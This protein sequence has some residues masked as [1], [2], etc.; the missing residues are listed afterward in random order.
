MKTMRFLKSTT[1]PTVSLLTVLFAFTTGTLY[2]QGFS[3]ANGLKLV[4]MNDKVNKNQFIW[5]SEA[6]LENTRGSSEGVTGTLTMD[7]RNLST[8]RGTVSTQVST[9][10]SGNDTRDHHLKSP[11]W[12]DANRYPAISFTI[13]SV[14][15]ISVSGNTATATVTGNF[16]MHGVS[17]QMSLPFKMTY[18]PESE[19]TRERAP[20]DLVMISADFN[21]SLKDFKIAGQE[22]TIGSKVGESI[23][24]TAQ[25]FGNAL[26]KGSQ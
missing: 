19:K 22:G 13:S 25:L 12:L 21:I 1:L 15:N 16:T 10:K 20:G 7:P 11:E 23:K 26:P 3:S 6:P 2:A 24:I 9:M 4:T 8:I 17:K 18:L 5:V 14:S